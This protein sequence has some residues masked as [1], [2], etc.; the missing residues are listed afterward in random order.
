MIRS[1]QA[2]GPRELSPP[3]G[4]LN[5]D[6]LQYHVLAVDAHVHLTPLAL[7][8]GS[9]RRRR[10]VQ[11]GR[12]RRHRV[13]P[14]QLHFRVRISRRRRPTVLEVRLGNGK[15]REAVEEPLRLVDLGR[16]G[17]HRGRRRVQL[18]VGGG[19]VRGRGGEPAALGGGGAAAEHREEGAVRIWRPPGFRERLSRRRILGRLARA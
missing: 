15:G 12:G 13:G 16:D 17:R 8:L 5:L 2:Q 4:P 11:R 14:P 19:R 3:V 9:R 7:L 1:A 10:P 6:D 18:Q